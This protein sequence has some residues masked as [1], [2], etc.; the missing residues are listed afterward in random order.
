V[1]A[2]DDRLLQ[3]LAWRVALASAL[4]ARA[5]AAMH[6]ATAGGKNRFRFASERAAYKA[7]AMHKRSELPRSDAPATSGDFNGL[8]GPLR[9]VQAS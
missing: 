8:S 7:P 1:P 5:D 9:L 6:A 2:H 3:A 4:P